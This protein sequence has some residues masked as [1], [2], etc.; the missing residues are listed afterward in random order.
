MTDEIDRNFG[1]LLYDAARLMRRDFDR[2]ARR[3]GLSRAQWSVL[4]HLARNE[5]VKQAE[6]AEVLDVQPITLARQI[7]RL[8]RSGL[9]CRC[10][11]PEDRRVRR[12]YLSELAGP[13][14]AELRA[15]GRQTRAEALRGLSAGQRRCLI[16]TLARI[17]DN[18][19]TGESALIKPGEEAHD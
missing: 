12:L 6:L 13:I 4:A 5:G 9:V 17:R 16:E 14:L 7:D 11:D 8:E 19:A 10:P 3:I 1:F 15:L 2:R 18:L